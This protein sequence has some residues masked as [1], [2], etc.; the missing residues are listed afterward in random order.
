[1]VEKPHTIEPNPFTG[2]LGGVRLRVA[3]RVNARDWQRTLGPLIQGEVGAVS[4][5]SLGQTPQAR[6]VRVPHESKVELLPRRLSPTSRRETPELPRLGRVEPPIAGLGEEPHRKRPP[7]M[8]Q[9][10]R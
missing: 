2:G 3:M 9:N 10:R 5:G 1:M 7:R 6:T 4:F 8:P